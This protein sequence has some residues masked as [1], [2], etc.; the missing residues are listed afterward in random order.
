[1]GWLPVTSGIWR[2][3]G[4]S[5]GLQDG[6]AAPPDLI[7]AASQ[8]F[9]ELSHLLLPPSLGSPADVPRDLLPRPVP[10][11]LV[12]SAVRAVPGPGDQRQGHVW[13]GQK[14][15]P[16]LTAVG[17][18]V[19]PEHEHVLWMVGPPRAHGGRRGRRRAV[20]PSGSSSSPSPVSTQ[21]A[22]QSGAVSPRRGLVAFPK[23]W[24]PRSAPLPRRSASVRK[25]G[26][27]VGAS[28][29]VLRCAHPSFWPR[30]PL[31]VKNAPNAPEAV[32]RQRL[33]PASC[34]A[35][36]ARTGG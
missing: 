29:V 21:T 18:A 35:S 5:L 28:A 12:S 25:G 11:R 36:A 32:I 24:L 7:R 4:I 33:Q 22:E 2:N 14:V 3:E 20:L 17:R 27:R 8:T 34:P 6:A 9:E 16:G 1:M 26:I 31:A 10:D 13:R 30:R 15:P 23:G 19:V